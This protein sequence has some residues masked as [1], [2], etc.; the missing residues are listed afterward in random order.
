MEERVVFVSLKVFA[1]F[2]VAHF[3][4]VFLRTFLYGVQLDCLL[5]FFDGS[6]EIGRWLWCFR[7]FEG[8]GRVYQKG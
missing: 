4:R 7:V 8:L 3:A 5:H 6:V 1:V 2:G